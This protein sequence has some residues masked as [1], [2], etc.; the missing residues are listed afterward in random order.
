MSMS[1]CSGPKV[2]QSSRLDPS[3]SVTGSIG[4]SALRVLICFRSSSFGRSAQKAYA[5]LKPPKF[6][7]VLLRKAIQTDENHALFVKVILTGI[8]ALKIATSHYASQRRGSK[9]TSARPLPHSSLQLA[10]RGT[11]EA[12]TQSQMHTWGAP[13][14]LPVDEHAGVL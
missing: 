4:M 3:F 5:P 11:G 7:V 10:I 12:F 14:L 8:V 13:E 9:D 6:T 1:I 2:H